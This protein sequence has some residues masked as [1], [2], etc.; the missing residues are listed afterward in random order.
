MLTVGIDVRPCY[1]TLMRLA[2]PITLLLAACDRGHPDREPPQ[3][4]G[5]SS[6]ST[7]GQRPRSNVQRPSPSPS[8]PPG[9]DKLAPVPDD[10]VAQV[11][12]EKI[13]DHFD[14]PVAYVV[15]HGEAFVVEQRGAIRIV[16]KKDAFFTIGGLSSGNEQG[17]L[18]LAFHPRFA[19]NHRLFV[20]YTTEDKRTHIVEYKA[21]GDRVDPRSAREI[22]VV[23]HPFSNHNGG[24]LVFGPDGKL[25]AGMGDGGSANDPYRNGQNDKALLAKILRFDVDADPKGTPTPEIVHIGMRNPWRFAFDKATGDLYIGDVGQNQW[26]EIDVVGG[27]DHAQKNFGWNVMEGTHCF[28]PETGTS[29]SCGVFARYTNPVAEYP[30]D[31]G[32]SVTGGVVYRGKALP[33]LEGMY[34]Y[35]DYCT[36]LLRSF[37][38]T[39]GPDASDPGWVRK[40][41]DWKGALDKDN[42]LS[43]VSSFGVDADGE[44][45]IVELTGQIYRLSKR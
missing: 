22:F 15:D 11:K 14:R 30:H 18:G 25:Y 8:P 24:N 37:Q 40:H 17:L 35:A 31:Q 12:L 2:I 3:D 34:F 6:P 5:S 43:Q 1:V 45:V 27:Q 9:D 28:D 36:G 44:I 20:D 39:P 32:C 42:V 13:G 23:D 41:W 38:W 21:D 10:L 33:A 26:E 19:D 4:P 29:K 7:S 16:G